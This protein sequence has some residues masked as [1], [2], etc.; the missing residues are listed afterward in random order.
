M[1]FG[2]GFTGLMLPKK[3]GFE[4]QDLYKE[5]NLI[6]G[7]AVGA[8]SVVNVPPGDPYQTLNNQENG[9]RLGLY[10]SDVT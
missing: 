1:G 3:A 4:Y 2:L 10:G 6:A 8:F 5:E 7:G 9:I